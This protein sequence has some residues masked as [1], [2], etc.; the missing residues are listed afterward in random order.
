MFTRYVLENPWPLGISLLAAAVILGWNALRGE[1]PVLLKGAGVIALLGALILFTG[2]MVVTA[3]ERARRVVLDV[4]AAAVAGDVRGAGAHFA[5]DATLSFGSPSNPGFSR[6]EIELRL[7]GLDD[8]YR[9]A[10]N[11]VA[12]LRAESAAPDLGVVYLACRTELVAAPVPVHTG[13][14][15]E[16]APQEGGAWKISRVTWISIAGR[17]PTPELGR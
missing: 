9:I 5:P 8:R 7:D 16:V 2:A 13:W 11:D 10:S 17:S 3:G 1:R 6:S 4:V 14:T 15:I 12:S